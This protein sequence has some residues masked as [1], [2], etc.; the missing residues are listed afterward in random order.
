MN[1]SSVLLLA[2]VLLTVVCGCSRKPTTEAQ[3]PSSADQ[4][5]EVKPDEPVIKAA[6]P[7][8][9]G[10]IATVVIPLAVLK[11]QAEASAKPVVV[12]TR[13]PQT[14]D[15]PVYRLSEE[16]KNFL[17]RVFPVK[18]YA[19][20]EFVVPPHQGHPTVHGVFQSFTNRDD[21][22][23]TSDKTADVD[24]MLLNEQEFDQFRRGQLESTTYD[25]DPA[26]NQTVDGECQ[27]P[28]AKRRRTI[29]CS[30]TL[31]ARG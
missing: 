24:L 8:D 1:R 20:F 17:H 25:L 27:P 16:P 3:A 22:D 28:S 21:P 23:S 5:P 19:Q 2:M 18:K 9:P 4:S 26:Y 12:E 30:V 14:V 13:E 15:H 11:K 7:E 29:W 6:T 31:T 10:P